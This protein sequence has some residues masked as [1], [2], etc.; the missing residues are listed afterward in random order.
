MKRSTVI[1]IVGL[2]VLAVVVMALEKMMHLKLLNSQSLVQTVA[3][4]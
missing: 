3:F 4:H 1:A 2:A